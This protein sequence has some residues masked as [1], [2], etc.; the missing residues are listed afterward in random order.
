M[1]RSFRPLSG[2]CVIVGAGL[3]AASCTDDGTN[4][5]SN[6]GN[7]QQFLLRRAQSCDD[8]L[9]SLKEDAVTKVN[10]YFDAQ[11]A[12]AKNGYM[13]IGIGRDMAADGK[14]GAPTQNA[15]TASNESSG[16][17]PGPGSGSGGTS[18]APMP[19][20]D[21]SSPSSDDRGGDSYGTGTNGSAASH[22]NTNTQ[23]QGVDEADIVKT[24]GKYLYI[25]HGQSLVV[26]NAWPASDLGQVS[27]FAVE[28]TPSEMFVA[29][30][31]DGTGQAVIYSTVDGAPIYKETGIKPRQEFSTDGSVG[32][33]SAGGD[34][35]MPAPPMGTGGSTGGASIGSAETPP[36]DPARKPDANVA[37]PPEPSVDDNPMPDP[38]PPIMDGGVAPDATPNPVEPGTKPLPPDAPAG[39]DARPADQYVYYPQLVKLTVIDLKQ[40]QPTLNR[41]IYFEGQYTSSRRVADFVR[42]VLNGGAFGPALQYSPYISDYN[43][44]PKTTAEWLPLFEKLRVDNIAKINATTIADWLPYYMVKQDGKL[45]G[46]T[47]S[48]SDYYVPKPGTTN[49]GLTQVHSIDLRAPNDAPRSSSIVGAVDTVYS[50]EKTMYL[51]ARGWV[52]PTE[53]IGKAIS[54]SSGGVATPDTVTTSPGSVSSPPSAGGGSSGSSGSSTGTG[55]APPA[56]IDAGAATPPMPPAQERGMGQAKLALEEEAPKPV[57]LARTF[58]HKFDLSANPAEPAYVASGVVKGAINNQ[59]A[60]DEDKNGF[61]R[62]CTTEEIYNG[63]A[64][65]VND[66]F[67]MTAV[68]NELKVVGSLENL[69]PNERIYS[70]RYVGDKAYI[71]TFRQVDPL[72]VID[73]SVPVAPKKLGELKIPGFSEYMHPLDEGHLLTIGQ[74]DRVLNLQIFDVTNPINPVQAFSFQF[75]PQD[76]G[77]SEAQQNHKAFTFF[78][79]KKLLA[80]PF[81]SYGS[82]GPRSTLEVFH[83][84]TSTGF[85]K[86]GAVDHSQF[87]QSGVRDYCGYYG[88]EVRRGVFLEDFVYSV[89]GGGVMVNNVSDLATTVAKMPLPAIVD[90]SKGCG[91]YP[92]GD[93]AMP[94]PAPLPPDQGIADGGAAGI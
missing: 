87:F 36:T 37:D 66:L 82:Q 30:N 88:M 21:P 45:K 22:S 31:A 57:S 20:A 80:F 42:T 64:S 83:V 26:L 43:Q 12:N 71:V 90:A 68:G 93:I 19:P 52:N 29:T 67:V 38:L 92:V 49:S 46:M 65:K 76:Y 13:G 14:T 50:N 6:V 58:V 59:F 61:L 73:L 7:A 3:L 60:L 41:E 11:V 33:G 40:A 54:G 72:F 79:E 2:L 16:G 25:L 53:L 78:A 91:G 4:N 51:A 84:D 77:Y 63:P 1:R 27:T 85:K 18:G 69:A 15:G 34:I 44:Y 48:C 10:Q 74:L 23:V 28:G 70:S 47:S 94:E 75:S 81:V 39:V 32:W 55:G 86:L 62:I 24:D 8:L 5:P 35:A 89:S 56:P 9:A 17:V